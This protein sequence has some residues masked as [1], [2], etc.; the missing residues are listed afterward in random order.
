MSLYLN[1]VAKDS[2]DCRDGTNNANT[3]S[4]IN[5]AAN[6]ANG[7]VLTSLNDIDKYLLK[8]PKK[9][10]RSITKQDTVMQ[11]VFGDYMC[12]VF[13]DMQ[14][15]WSQF[16]F[17]D[18]KEQHVVVDLLDIVKRTDCIKVKPNASHDD[19]LLV[20]EDF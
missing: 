9:T 19:E 12:G 6:G 7:I 10:Q 13:H 16:G 2:R 4:S 8:K 1:I 20:D 17:M 5:L 3:C 15:Y 14:E 11:D 18:M